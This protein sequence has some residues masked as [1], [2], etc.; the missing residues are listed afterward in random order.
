MNVQEKETEYIRILDSLQNIK[1]GVVQDCTTDLMLT[2]M[3]PVKAQKELKVLANITGAVFCGLNALGKQ[4]EEK[5]EQEGLVFITIGG[6]VFSCA[7]ANLILDK[8]DSPLSASEAYSVAKPQTVVEAPKVEEAPVVSSAPAVPTVSEDEYEEEE[9]DEPFNMPASIPVAPSPSPVSNLAEEEEEEDEP[10]FTA[11]VKEEPAPIPAVEEEYEEEEE[12]DI[13]TETETPSIPNVED[14]SILN[15]LNFANNVEEEDTNKEDDVEI[16]EPE[17][18]V[19]EEVKTPTTG[20]AKII[21]ATPAVTNVFSS[22]DLFLEERIKNG[23]EFVYNYSKISVM[24]QEMGSK[25]E[26]MHVLIA[27]LKITKYSCTSVPIVVTVMH[28]GRT[29]TASSY[30]TKDTGKNIVLFDINEY[31]FLARGAI[32]ENGNFKATLTT[33]GI[34]ANQGDKINV[35]S[36]KTYGNCQNKATKNGHVK[37]RY[38]AESG[39]GTIEVFPFG[40]I[41]DEDFVAIVKNEEFVDYYVLSKSFRA[42]QRPIIY[43]E[44]GEPSEL[45][46]HWDGDNLQ[47]ELL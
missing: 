19:V 34:S 41:G 18:E 27:P 46:C 38:T 30:D 23:N 32:D 26:E 10:V 14:N 20:G 22:E 25:P 33:T 37:F 17:P 16:T 8:M 3:M 7:K 9:E 40:D 28:N 11:E 39:P 43:T 15:L 6:K 12:E 13:P 44:T 2:G 21:G 4:I 42:N 1:N 5:E 47:A 35:I 24:H 36:S 29:V 31:Y 45:L